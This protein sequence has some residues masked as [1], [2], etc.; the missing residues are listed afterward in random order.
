[1]ETTNAVQTWLWKPHDAITISITKEPGFGPDLDLAGHGEP[2]DVEE[3]LERLIIEANEAL[4]LY[5]QLQADHGTPDDEADE[6]APAWP[7]LDFSGAP[8][9]VPAVWNYLR[10]NGYGSPA[11]IADALALVTTAQATEALKW[12]AQQGRVATP[13]R[14]GT[15]AEWTL[16]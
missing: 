5:R 11:G 14:Y 13:A 15:L 7:D 1:M 16:S 2:F 8:S 6:A 9:R 12:L 10:E 3:T 4:V